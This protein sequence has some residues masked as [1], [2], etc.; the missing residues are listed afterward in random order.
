MLKFT[1]IYN[2]KDANPQ[3]EYNTE[4]FKI[5]Q[6]NAASFR[7][8]SQILEERNAKLNGI[9][10]KHEEASETMRAETMGLQTR[11]S[12]VRNALLHNIQFNRNL[13]RVQYW[14]RQRSASQEMERNLPT[15]LLLAA[16]GSVWLVLNSPPFPV[17]RFVY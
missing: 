1:K 11:L 5:A 15:A 16:T 13:L 6:A 8:Q 12:Q 7:K 17:W 3:E 14:V 9:V 10:A 2:I 4:R